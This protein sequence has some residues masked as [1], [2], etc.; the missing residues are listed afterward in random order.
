MK[1]RVSWNS[2]RDAP[3]QNLIWWRGIHASK[4]GPPLITWQQCTKLSL[5]WHVLTLF[6]DWTD[7]VAGQPG[8]VAGIRVKE[9][10]V[11]VVHWCACSVLTLARVE[12]CRHVARRFF[13]GF[14]PVDSS[15]LPLH[16]G[17]F[18]NTFWE[19][20]FLGLDQTPFFSRTRFDTSCWVIPEIKHT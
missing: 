12:A 16:D 6:A 20:W 8:S 4:P 7:N 10:V 17:M 1:P 14:S 11:H 2:A 18:K 5:M 19:L 3:D 13:V 15:C 9:C